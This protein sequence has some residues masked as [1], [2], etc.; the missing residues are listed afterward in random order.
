M[1]LN[2]CQY[3]NCTIRPTFNFINE[4]K[5]LFCAK[6]KQEGMVD[7]K[8]KRC[9]E[10]NCC[11]QP[12]YNFKDENK[13]LYCYKHK[14][15]GMI[16]VKNKKCKE[17]NCNKQPV[18]NYEDKIKGEYCYIHKKEGMINI[19]TKNCIEDNCNTRPSFNYKDEIV[20]LYCSKHKKE[21]MIDIVNNN[22]CIIK[23]CNIYASFNF[24]G[25]DKAYY[26]KTHKKDGM[27][28]VNHN[29]CIY[30]SCEKRPSFNYLNESEPIYCSIHKLDDMIN[31]AHKKCKTDLCYTIPSNKI[32]D[33]Y[34]LR[35]FVYLFPDMPNSRNYKTKECSVVEFIKKEFENKTIITDKKIQDGCSRRRPDILI[36]LG[37]QVII[38]E[39]DE[40]QHIDY[41]CSCENKRIMELSQDIGH[42]PL[43]FIRFNPDEYLDKDNNKIT[44][45]WG[46]DGRGI[47]S[48]KKSKTKEWNERLDRLKEQIQYW[49]DN[50]TDKT[51]EIIQ[52]YYNQNI[53]K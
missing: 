37:Y 2:K 46:I 12:V 14:K 40:N 51:V 10:K 19:K 1:S 41:E 44:S 3:I 36:D 6:H 39:I 16:D 28:N 18:F 24:K 45:C 47:C 31:V 52:L 30:D 35:C 27:I 7:V 25:K 38:I 49:I 11:T 29:T 50:K 22:K 5:A 9:L 42:R 17:D 8:S 13:P 53:S 15:E 33:G 26:C 34:C 21:D 23:N 43:I 4:K 48:I 20:A 32:Y